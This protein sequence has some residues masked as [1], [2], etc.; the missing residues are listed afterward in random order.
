M[1]YLSHIPPLPQIN[2]LAR[3]HL[4]PVKVKDLQEDLKVMYQRQ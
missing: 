4:I 2:M 3:C 1:P